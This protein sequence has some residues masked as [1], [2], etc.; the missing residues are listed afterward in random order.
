MTAKELENKIKELEE[1][2]LRLTIENEYLKKVGCLSCR[3]KEERVKEI[4]K[5]ITELRKE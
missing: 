2:N 1:K 5:A 3:T 4:V